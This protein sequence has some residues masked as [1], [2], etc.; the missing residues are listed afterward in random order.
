MFV[1]L[2]YLIV[3]IAAIFFALGIG[4]MIGFNLNNSEILSN[5]QVKL[6]EDMDSKLNEL[7]I[8]N[9]ELQT[10]STSQALINESYESF[11]DN[12]SGILLKDMLI[13]KNIILIQST[14][15]YFFPD[16]NEFYASSGINIEYHAV[17][18]TP[19]QNQN[20]N[21]VKYPEIFEENNTINYKKLYSL[22]TEDLI[23]KNNQ[24][25]NMYVE[26]KIIDIIYQNPSENGISNVVLIGGSQEKNPNSFDNI[27]SA[28]IS[29]A[30]QLNTNIIGAEDS[31]VLYSYIENFKNSEISTVD[32]LDQTIGKIS[33]A[34]IINGTGGNYGSKDTA[35]SLFPKTK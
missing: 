25:I 30:K 34:F 29:T 15:D 28:V 18:N 21:A 10:D 19:E 2:K 35:Q 12:Y 16:L 3:T 6:I 5:Q 31:K 9:D 7:R 33:L 27:D 20:I 23:N 1:N 26:D 13:G 11:L 32:N 22:I 8:K 24:K 4:I 14:D 17:I